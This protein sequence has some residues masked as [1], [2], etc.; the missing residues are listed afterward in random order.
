MYKVYD[1][2]KTSFK[3]IKNNDGKYKY[4][5][6]VEN[7]YIEVTREV[8]LVCMSSYAKIKY[9][10]QKEVARSVKYYEDV[11]QVTSF[12]LSNKTLDINTKIFINDLA[13]LAIQ[14]IHKLPDKYRNIAICLFLDELSERTTATRL[15]IPKSTVHKRKI[16]IQKILQEK[17]KKGGQ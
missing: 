12:I 16:V 15:S 4:F 17:L 6:K 5:I 2:D 3:K 9:D 11:D 13:N 1:Y 7:E 10:S 14:E 8:Y